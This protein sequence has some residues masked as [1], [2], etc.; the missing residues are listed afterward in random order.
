MV[1]RHFRPVCLGLALFLIACHDGAGP[2]DNGLPSRDDSEIPSRDHSP[3]QTDSVAYGLV[4][5]PGEY[6]TFVWATYRNSTDAPVY[7]ARCDNHSTLPM[8]SVR[9][10]GPDSLRRMFVDWAWACVGG[11][12]TGVIE[13]G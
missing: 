4:R 6:R 7:F 5:L 2:N 13:A 11:V 8:F 10:T 3:A 12:P 1:P 9:R